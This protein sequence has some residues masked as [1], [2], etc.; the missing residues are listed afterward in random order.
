M[1]SELSLSNWIGFGVWLLVGLF[2][3]LGY[4]RKNSKLNVGEV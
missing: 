3:Y 2:I 4:S 1:M